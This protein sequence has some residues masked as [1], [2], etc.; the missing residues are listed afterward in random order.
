MKTNEILK[1]KLQ[2]I[3]DTKNESIRKEVAQEALE[4]C[5]IKSFFSDLLFHG[6]ASGMIGSLIYYVDTHKFYDTHYNEI[7]EIR[8]E[9]EDSIGESLKI[10][11][12]LKNFLA[13]FAFEQVAYELAQELGIEV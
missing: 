3:I 11:G 9:Y 1:E 8:E 13:W 6:C 12:D 7:E 10:N 5:D 2:E 4:Y